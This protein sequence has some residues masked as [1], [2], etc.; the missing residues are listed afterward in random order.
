MIEQ[1]TKKI[2]LDMDAVEEFFEEYD[3]S[4][5]IGW[6][7]EIL[8]G[9]IKIELMRKAVISH[10]VGKKEKCQKFVDDMFVTKWWEA[11]ND[12]K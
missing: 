2:H 12:T 9:N 10:S 1:V 11:D 7:Q 6:L 8:N 4:G 5:S 3:H